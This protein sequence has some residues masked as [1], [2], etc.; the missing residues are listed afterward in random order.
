MSRDIK[1]RIYDDVH[2]VIVFID[3]AFKMYFDDKHFESYELIF[4]ENKNLICRGFDTIDGDYGDEIINDTYFNLQQYTGIK[5]KNNVEI[6]EG[7]ICKGNFLGN[8]NEL[9]IIKFGKYKTKNWKDLYGICNTCQYGWYA[10]YINDKSQVHLVSPNG[11]KVVGNIF[12]NKELL[13][14]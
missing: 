5:D 4:D 3:E 10:E 1:F 9:F 14:K 6:Y 7:D 8:D 13:K 11:I 2:K 12:E